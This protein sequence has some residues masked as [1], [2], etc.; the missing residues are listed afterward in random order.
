MVLRKLLNKTVD[1]SPEAQRSGC[2]RVRTVGEIVPCS[3]LAEASS[4][5]DNWQLVER[6]EGK[7]R[8]AIGRVWGEA[9]VESTGK[10]SK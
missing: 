10:R 7:I 5:P 9:E 8:A 1:E 6:M 2:G 4:L 3:G